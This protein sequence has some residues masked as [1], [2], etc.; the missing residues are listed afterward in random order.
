[1]EPLTGFAIGG[2]VNIASVVGQRLFEVWRDFSR[3]TAA[4]REFAAFSREINTFASDWVLVQPCLRSPNYSL[5]DEILGT[6]AHIAYDTRYIL[7]DLHRMVDSFRNQNDLADRVRKRWFICTASPPEGERRERL[8]RFLIWRK[9]VVQRNQIVF[10]T[11]TLNVVLAA[12][13]Y[14]IVEL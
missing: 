1:M 13:Q 3:V 8:R 2:L 6:L 5:S 4:I 10:A 14:T 9:I 11:T 7:S 12:I